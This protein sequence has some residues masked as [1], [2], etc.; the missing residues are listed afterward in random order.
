M[1]ESTHWSTIEFRFLFLAPEIG[2]E[3]VGVTNK[4]VVMGT[5]A[6]TT[7]NVTTRRRLADVSNA[8]NIVGRQPDS[9]KPSAISHDVENKQPLVIEFCVDFISCI[10]VGDAYVGFMIFLNP[11]PNVLGIV[12]ADIEK[13]K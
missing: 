9:E 3:N 8:N 7:A 6:Q 11:M 4:A 2:S 13:K 1:W 12:C 5:R 10:I